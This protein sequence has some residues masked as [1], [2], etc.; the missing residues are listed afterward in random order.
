MNKQH[1]IE[2]IIRTAKENN[3]IPLGKARFETETGIK[4]C[5]WHGKYWAK[6]NDAIK[7]ADLMPNK[8]T[9]A[10]NESWLIEQFISLIREIGKFPSEGEI[11]LKAYNA[12]NFPASSTFN[13]LGTTTKRANT[14]LAYCEGK[15]DH[16]DVSEICRS[17]ISSLRRDTDN[18]SK[19]DAEAENEIG[20]VYLMK[21]GSY[22][23][24]GR[25]T[26]VE[27]RNYEIGIKL[28]EKFEIVHKIRT[29]DPSGIET[30]WHDRFKDKRKQGEWFDLSSND[31]NAF[32]RRKFM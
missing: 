16:Q 26:N 23:K 10:Y 28:P 21:S 12:K 9:T 31:I 30:Y 27:R 19:E 6:W 32:K 5:E 24:L 18:Y 25:S 20:Y 4:Y 29:D 1:I 13:R 17:Y 22:Y 7:E 11:R 3:G 2:E 14:I 15:L 8:M